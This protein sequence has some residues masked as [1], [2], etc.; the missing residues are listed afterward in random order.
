MTT[1]EQ[2]QEAASRRAAAYPDLHGVRRVAVLGAGVIGVSWCAWFLARGFEVAVFDP[3]ADARA[4]VAGFVARAWPSLQALGLVL[5]DTDGSRLQ[6]HDDVVGAV[7]GAQFVQECGPDRL[8]LKQ[9]L[10]DAV[11][12]ALAPGVVVA[13]STSSLL[14]SDLQAGRRHAQRYVAGH[15]FNPPHLVPLVEV[16]GGSLTDPAAVDWAMAFYRVNGR[17]PVRLGQGGR[18]PHCQPSHRGALPGGGAHRLRGH[19]QR[20]GR[21]RRRALRTRVALRHH[22]TTPDLSPGWR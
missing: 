19:R 10:F 22:G 5:P 17:H 2:T 13:T 20:A 18:R 1:D 7:A 6:V 9:A 4:S 21:R 16:V 12:A 3:D 14:V 15:H 11:D 8:P